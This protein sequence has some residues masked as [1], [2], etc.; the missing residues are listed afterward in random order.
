M[1][2]LII[3]I[4]SFSFFWVVNK[5]ALHDHF[6]NTFMGRTALAAM[7]V[8]TGSAH[9]FKRVEMVQMMPEFLPF[10]I[11]FVYFTGMFELLGAVGLLITQTARWTSIALILFFL[12]ILPANIIG[13]LKKVELGGMEN[14]PGY[15]YFRIP[16]Q[17]FFIWWTYYFGIRKFRSSFNAKYQVKYI[18]KTNV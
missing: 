12:C 13:S 10:K 14:G 16:L 3:L 4:L 6:T 17:I 5:Y 8:L 11:Q 1:A 7:L 18:P 9:F 2:T 15:L